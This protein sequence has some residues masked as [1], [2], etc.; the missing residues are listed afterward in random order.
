V[1][2]RLGTVLLLLVVMAV[3]SVGV[4]YA[5]GDGA[6]SPAARSTLSTAAP[7]QTGRQL[8]PGQAPLA[9]ACAPGAT[10]SPACDVNHDG[11]MDVVDV[12]LTA[13]RWGQTGTYV[14]GAA[15]P[16]F[17]NANRYVDC[18]NGTVTDTVTGL[19][20]LKDANCYN[21]TYAGAN[22]WAATL[23]D[24]MCGLTDNSSP[25]DWRLPTKAEWEATEARASALGC[26]A[27][28]G[29]GPALTN[30]PGT[31][32]YNA[33]PQPFTGV[34]TVYH[35]STAN[36]VNPANNWWTDIAFGNMQHD[37]KI[38]GKSVWPVRSAK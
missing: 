25:G 10:Y 13:G 20:W 37:A 16:C 14:A 27:D 30:T 8:T 28:F 12:Q 4:L 17:D 6:A 7:A 33:G 32:C 24:G 36:E 1:R 11:V 34:Q 26:T 29:N 9:A 38:N 21:D 15:P 18:G 3:A 31:G 22:T 19:V 2:N 23:Q 5:A 35:S